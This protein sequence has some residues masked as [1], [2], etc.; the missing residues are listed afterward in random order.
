MGKKRER[1]KQTAG[2]TELL[3]QKIAELEAALAGKDAQLAELK[4]RHDLLSNIVNSTLDGL[5]VIDREFTIIAI[6]DSVRSR[7]GNA[8][9]VGRKC[10]EVFRNFS[11]M[12]G[13]C[14]SRRAMETGKPTYDVIRRRNSDG[15]VTSWV[16][17]YCYPLRSPDGKIIGSVECSRYADTHGLASGM[18]DEMAGAYTSIIES[19]RDAIVIVQD[20]VLKY[21]N[22][23]AETVTGYSAAELEGSPFTSLLPR[24]SWTTEEENYRLFL[25][26]AEGQGE[27]ELKITRRDGR[28]CELS[29]FY[30]RLLFRGRPAVIAIG[31]DIS[32]HKE[33][34][35]SLANAEA[36]WRAL[37]RGIPY[38]VAV[39]D[40][41]GRIIT[42]NRIE[43][44]R[45]A[46]EIIGHTVWEFVEDSYADEVK[47]N[48]ESVFQSGATLTGEADYSDPAGNTRRL[49]Y[50]MTVAEFG[51]G[52]EHAI[53]TA[54][55]VSHRRNLEDQLRLLNMAIEQSSE[56][57][58]TVDPDGN[59]LFVNRAFAE[60]HGYSVEELYGKDLSIFHTPDQMP[61]V[62]K[63]NRIICERGWFKGEIMHARRDG[64][65][66]PTYMFNSLIRDA[67]G[68]I[69]GMLGTMRDIS[70]EKLM[71]S[72]VRESEDLYRILFEKSP[73]GVGL[74]AM[75]G[76]IITHN[77]AI[78][79]S[80]GY[81]EGDPDVPKRIIDFYVD[82]SEYDRL[83][84]IVQEQGFVDNAEVMFK[85]KNGEHYKVLVSVRPVVFKAEWCFLAIVQDMTERIEADRKVRESEAMFRT[86]FESA[87]LGIGISDRNGK[88][89]AY[90]DATFLP[91]GYTR[92]EVDEHPYITR[93]YYNP[94]DRETI[95]A[96]VREKGGIRNAEVKFKRKDG[97]AF[98][99]LLS[100]SPITFRGE[101]YQL[102]IVQDVTESRRMEGQLRQIQKLDSIGRLAGGVAHDF[103]NLLTA[104]MGYAETARG[105]LSGNH[106]A[107]G[108]IDE[109]LAAS[110]KA[111]NL[112]RQLL[113][114]SSHQMISPR[115]VNLNNIVSN[116]DKMLRRLITENVEFQTVLADDL[117]TV[118]ADPGQIEQILVNM[119]INAR[120]AMPDG[121]RLTIES[122]N[123]SLDA[124]YVRLHHG[125]H[126]GDYVMLAVS[127]TGL[128]MTDEIKSRLF[129][130]FFTTKAKDKGTGL[131]LSTCYGIARQS[132][133]HIQ[134]YSEPGRGS[135][136]SLYLPRVADKA[137]PLDMREESAIL[138]EG[139]E[140]IL[141]VENEETVRRMASR[142]LT[143]QGYEVLEACDGREA[144]DVVRQRGIDKIDM[145]L[146]DVVMP[147][148]GGKQLADRLR[149]LR[150]ELKVLF[151]SGYSDN[152]AALADIIR[153]GREFM[154]KPFS[155]L[156]L[157][158]K[159]RAIL[160][161][162]EP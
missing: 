49:E 95:I 149:A 127:D 12:C 88:L 1:V 37:L 111:A 23:A 21:I 121:G 17:M 107:S 62:N 52:V 100:V 136:F 46:A 38:K 4:A 3:K 155:P 94:A 92:E 76:T 27:N 42:V 36:R 143:Q 130:P 16:D 151:I 85:R 160:D 124:E 68:R 81:M 39:T 84:V 73:I 59:I 109:V 141:L 123:R 29:V 131:G 86:L 157:A 150:P 158:V 139:D 114:F 159:I 117:G 122:A 152:A 113:A 135:T 115:P 78:L 120:D 31:R 64:T 102:A 50:S 96:Q 58:A 103:N 154:Q 54:R 24:E 79:K 18:F 55:D 74:G 80:A 6:N 66:F 145:L 11:S 51:D 138:P 156:K 132:G 83:G 9:I 34:E 146:T 47:R 112:T 90:N 67:S 104:I 105:A 15:A 45:D 140:T 148:M 5:C 22:K 119:V 8:N 144:L 28:E 72:K 128:G 10:Y 91:G 147:R 108:D 63:A 133:G 106:P 116:M 57:V 118:R 70:D 89:V 77:P 33:M 137:M 69:M 75:D 41:E 20:G 25:T 93:F 26:R 30:G 87:P 161:A 162:R 97:S 82:P 48:L 35:R 7:A 44:G 53:V 61:A 142:V 2:E 65:P 71:Q 56:G 129:E 13:D 134:V 32:E 101:Q 99:T 19:G 98:D 43:Q 40:R 110:H 153:K 126:P 60:M 14:P 125:V